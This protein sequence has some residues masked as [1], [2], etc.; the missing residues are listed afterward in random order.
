MYTDHM[1]L[2]PC[3]TALFNQHLPVTRVLGVDGGLPN[4]LF[5]RTG[6]ALA[7]T[8]RGALKTAR[9]LTGWDVGIS[10][11]PTDGL[12]TGWDVGIGIKSTDGA[13]GVGGAAICGIRDGG[14]A[15]GRMGPAAVGGARGST[16]TTLIVTLLP[17]STTTLLVTL[18]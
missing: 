10:I 11:H 13:G 9:L 17:L 14:P 6:L 3:S 16:A 8:R 5:F 7:Q 15:R 2:Q 1:C 4:P 12:L 18:C